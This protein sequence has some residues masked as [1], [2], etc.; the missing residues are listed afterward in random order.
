M[1]EYLHKMKMCVD[2]LVVAAH[3]VTD[4]DLILYILGGLGQEFDVVV[5]SVTVRAELIS[6]SNLQG[7]LLSYEYHLEQ[8]IS[9]EQGLGQVNLSAK[10]SN[11]PKNDN[12]KPT[13]FN[14]NQVYGGRSRR[15]Q[16]RGR[17]TNSSNQNQCQVCNKFGHSTLN[18]Y[19]HFDHAYQVLSKSHMA[20]VIAQPSAVGDSNWYPDSG[21]TYHLTNDMQN[22]AV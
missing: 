21:A 8:M 22:I 9:L 19:H 2:N 4:D 15:G 14:N 10:Q 1:V 17:N 12:N 3:P 16:G 11:N 13:S 7:L 6:L 20:V 5:V 18:C